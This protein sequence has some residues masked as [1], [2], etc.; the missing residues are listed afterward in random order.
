M[1]LDVEKSLNLV[2]EQDVA[3]MR[4]LLMYV[5]SEHDL[6]A[7]RIF[8]DRDNLIRYLPLSFGY[9]EYTPSSEYWTIC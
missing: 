4:D 2:T 3:H 8:L 7:L 1:R 9:N 6:S 5:E